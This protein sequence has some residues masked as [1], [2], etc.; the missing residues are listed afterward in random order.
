MKTPQMLHIFLL[1]SE[2][3]RK[4]IQGFVARRNEHR[5]SGRPYIYG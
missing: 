2:S 4:I 3:L 1:K 5:T